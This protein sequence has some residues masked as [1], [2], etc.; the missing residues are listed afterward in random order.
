[1]DELAEFAEI[2]GLNYLCNGLLTG[3]IFLRHAALM[4]DLFYALLDWMYVHGGISLFM[5]I[6]EEN[7]N[8]VMRA[9]PSG[10]MGD[11]NPDPVFLKEIK[12]DGGEYSR[13]SLE[14]AEGIW[15]VFPRGGAGLD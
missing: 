2:T 10:D 11:F 3:K 8:I 9:M 1:M 6:A 4:Y 5:Q 15:L 14:D 7:G 13:K 12:A